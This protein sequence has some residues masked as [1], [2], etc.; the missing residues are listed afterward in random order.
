MKIL[1][2]N[3]LSDTAPPEEGAETVRGK[4]FALCKRNSIYRGS[5]RTANPAR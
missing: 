4:G 1:R 5:C 2:P 3:G